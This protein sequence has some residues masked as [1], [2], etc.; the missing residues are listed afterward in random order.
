MHFFIDT[1]IIS[2]LSF[3]IYQWYNFY[4]FYWRFFMK[5]IP[6]S[7]RIKSA[8]SQIVAFEKQ[9]FDLVHD[10]IFPKQPPLEGYRKIQLRKSRDLIS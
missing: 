7:E 5:P 9:V 10:K 6:D 1:L 3:F 8:Y 4:V 2:F